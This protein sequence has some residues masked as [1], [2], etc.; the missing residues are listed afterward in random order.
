MPE[1][2][3]TPGARVIAD[4]HLDPHA[5]GPWNAFR[6]WLARLEA[7]ALLVLGDLFEYWT[8]APPARQPEYVA[9]LDELRARAARGTALH[10]LH[11]NRDFLLGRSFERAVGGRVHARG[12][13]GRTPAG[14]R[15]LFLHGDELAT[16]DRSYQRLRLVLRNPLVRG[17]VQATPAALSR[18]AARVLRRRSRSAVAAK[19]LSTVELQGDAVRAWC[20]RHDARHLVCGHAHRFRDE[21]LAT[22]GR[23]I[24]LDAFGGARDVLRLDARGEL[25]AESS[26]QH[27]DAAL[28]PAPRALS[29]GAQMIVAL[30]GPAGVGKSSVARALARALG[31]FF[32]DT[33]AMYRAVTLAVLERDLEPADAT[34]CTR[35]AEELVLAFDAQGRILLDG[36][37]GEPAIRGPAVTHAVSLVSAHGGVRAAV[38]A[39]QRELVAST[40][41]VVAEGRDTTTVVF[42]RATHKFYLSASAAERARRRALQEGTPGRRAE[43][44]AEL[45][46]R[47]VLDSTRAHS[48]LRFTADALR[49]ET[50]GL[51]QEQV[52]ARLLAHVRGERA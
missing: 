20:A 38:V 6:A 17:L 16:R 42:P 43:I 36:R 28:Q 50:D 35:V 47:D 23:W 14:A 48:P 44:E 12:L 5:A 30:D 29:S 40:P 4:L 21:A 11:G 18:A 52:V 41:G 33:G 9:L 25:V 22:G 3:L 26:A 19:S 32:L 39:R 7:P 31:F 45:E 51:T 8:G 49:I 1:I 2:A 13:L 27:A 46:R 24:V 34:A 37:A 15:V 10:F